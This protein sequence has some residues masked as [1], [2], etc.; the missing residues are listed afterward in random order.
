MFLKHQQ[1]THLIQLDQS[2]LSTVNALINTQY[3]KAL[4]CRQMEHLNIYTMEMHDSM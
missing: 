1:R 3:I 4:Y 2:Q